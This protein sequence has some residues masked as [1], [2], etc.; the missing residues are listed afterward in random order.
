MF[1]STLRWLLVVGLLFA[2]QFS[3]AQAKKGK[4]PRLKP[5][6]KVIVDWSGEQVGEFIEY[7]GTGWLRVKVKG[8]T[9]AEQTPV[10]PPDSVRLPPKSET[11]PVAGVGLH[12]WVDT[13]GKYKTE[14]TFLRLADG[15]VELK[16]AD[17]SI[18]K[19][20]L[21]KLSAADQELAKKL[22]EADA[23][24]GR[25]PNDPFATTEPAKPGI[26]TE[27]AEPAPAQPAN[28]TDTQNP[29]NL[30]VTEPNRGGDS[31]LLLDDSVR[32]GGLTA[33]PEPANAVSLPSRGIP[34]SKTVPGKEGPAGGFF[35]HSKLFAV[36]PSG[37]SAVIALVDESP[38]T[39]RFTRLE[40]C[41][42][43]AGK[44]LGSSELKGNSVPL[45]ADPTG[46]FIVCRSD[47]FHIG[48]HGRVDI[49][50]V[51]QSQL[52][53]VISWLPYGDRDWG[54]RDVQFASFLD[55]GH[56]CTV[57]GTGKLTVWDASQA[58]AIFSVA[59]FQGSTPAVSGTGKYLA[60]LTKGGIYVLDSL[61]GNPLARLVG[62][63]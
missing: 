61:S 18:A 35:E 48:T 5:G 40:R 31:E 2:P 46:Q 28:H 25:D 42:L 21:D 49:F 45:D 53:H 33:D 50:D 41:D 57:D 12:T 8:A 4:L 30:K 27:P 62:Q 59:T 43:A 3:L 47:N 11:R 55:N 24:A 58:K 15:K 9:G 56:I 22:A 38:G 26:P 29:A 19:V 13:T 51:S 54:Q 17:G 10:F 1:A 20:P 32:E 63:P 44:S 39:E 34:L 52:K 6:D 37:G 60:V 36:S 7:T 23:A 14:A 16:K